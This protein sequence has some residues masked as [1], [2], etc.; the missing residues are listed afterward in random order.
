MDK[1]VQRGGNGAR[2][3]EARVR[4]R[5]GAVWVPRGEEGA[6]ADVDAADG[7]EGWHVKM[8]TFPQLE[9]CDP[10]PRWAG[11][12][13]G[14]HTDEVLMGEL[15]LRA[16]E[17]DCLQEE[18]VVQCPCTN[19]CL[20]CPMGDAIHMLF[21]SAHAACTTS[22]LYSSNPPAAILTPQPGD[23]DSL[24]GPLGRLATSG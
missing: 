14:A 6:D 20:D 19:R 16:E 1:C 9:R 10:K 7:G 3:A 23:I 22:S 21:C 8:G 12:D 2:M 11:P 15:G 18:G 13:L 5:T 17:T 24:L 4:A